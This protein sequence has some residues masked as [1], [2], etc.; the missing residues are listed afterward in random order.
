MAKR[1][2]ICN[3]ALAALNFCVYIREKVSKDE[4]TIIG[5]ATDED[6]ESDY[7]YLNHVDQVIPAHIG[8]YMDIEGIIKICLENNIKYAALGWG[9]LS[10]REDFAKALEDNDII[11]LGPSST[12][13]AALGDKVGSMILAE[14][15]GVPMAK[16]SGNQKLDSVEKCIAAV[17]NVGVPAMIKS[18]SGGGGRGIRAIRDLSEVASAYHNI[19]AEMKKSPEDSDVF[20]MKMIENAMHL[21]VQIVG[22]GKNAVHCYSRDCSCQ[23]SNQK[24]SES[25]VIEGE[26]IPSE[27]LKEIQE[28]AVR[29]A[30][31][32]NYKGLGTAEFLYNPESQE[33]VFLEK[34]VRQQVESNVTSILLNINLVHILYEICVNNK[35]IYELGLDK[36]DPP[37]GHVVAARLNAEDPYN[38]FLP[39]CGNVRSIEIPHMLRTWSYTS[40]Y[41]GGVIKNTMDGQLGHLFVKGNSREEACERMVRLIDSTIIDAD[42]PN[43][44]AFL[45][46]V[47]K[48]PTFV[49]NEHTTCWVKCMPRMIKPI[50]PETDTIETIIGLMTQG[51]FRY[52]MNF[53][54][55]QDLKQRGHHVEYKK[56]VPVAVTRFSSQSQAMALCNLDNNNSYVKGSVRIDK[57]RQ[58][59]SRINCELILFLPEINSKITCTIEARSREVIVLSF[60]HFM[61]RVNV[62]SAD[63]DFSSFRIQIKNRTRNFQEPIDPLEVRSKLDGKL[64]QVFV[65]DEC[66]VSAGQ[67]I[68]AL[69][70]MKMLFPVNVERD[71]NFK[72]TCQVGDLIKVGMLLGRFVEDDEESPLKKGKSKPNN[73]A[74][75]W[76]PEWLEEFVSDI[77]V[78]DFE[79]PQKEI[80]K[81]EKPLTPIEFLEKFEWSHIASVEDSS[82]IIPRNEYWQSFDFGFKSGI[83][84]WV[85]YEEFLMKPKCVLITHNQSIGYGSFSMDECVVFKKASELARKYECPRVYIANSSGARLDYISPNVIK[86]IQ[87]DSDKEQC[88]ITKSNFKLISE[89][90]QKR[91]VIDGDNID[92]IYISAIKNDGANNLDGCAMIASET[93]LAYDLI[94]TISYCSTYSVGIAAY[95]CRLGHRVIQK[96][97]SSLLLT[98]YRALNQLLSDDSIYQS[99]EQLGGVGVMGPNGVS[100]RI[101]ETDEQGVASIEQ[102]LRFV[103]YKT[104]V[105]NDTVY[106]KDRVPETLKNIVDTNSFYELMKGYATG[107][108]TGRARIGGTS[109]GVIFPNPYPCKKEVPVNPEDK[110]S[111]KQISNVAPSVLYPDTSYKFAQAI[112][113]VNREGLPLLIVLNLRG[114]SGGTMAMFTEVL[115]MGSKILDALRVFNQKCIL[116]IPDKSELRGGAQVVLSKSVNPDKIHFWVSDK[117]RVNILEVAG[118]F[119]VKY[120]KHIFR[121]P[122]HEGG[123]KQ[124]GTVDKAVELHDK[125]VNDNDLYEIVPDNQLRDKIINDLEL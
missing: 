2:L 45:K 1:L 3:R 18:A 124:S 57:C 35:T 25:S 5:L 64:V 31:S 48:N 110:S 97:G 104:S 7:K 107:I 70:S 79:E 23:R 118:G 22:D 62:C 59:D 34:N 30:E 101:V 26:H 67:S 94:P 75:L 49:R 73:A 58:I 121:P 69:E 8:I 74:S 68:V 13:I 112:N 47:F 76:F 39:A 50:S 32:V 14:K 54:R 10:E 114:F 29:L 42:F 24:I 43:T 98:G 38:D 40:I 60:G 93:S 37:K 96:K 51:Y 91:L 84:A 109:F 92:K 17:E 88:Y 66:V 122:R 20:V 117:S 15:A 95:L 86:M 105:P 36:L 116:Y 65:E 21:E 111:S 63:N 33:L 6:I 123:I 83:N 99:N 77:E 100:Q 72:L 106:I 113:D 78:D 61:F 9:F 115:K 12:A 90:N 108:K 103:N 80:K 125:V 119:D 82:K 56:D 87:Y 11:A 81:A 4:L 102:Y 44:L 19:N 85:L 120:K 27:V 53:A 71:G 89:E 52:C 41:S 46:T 28:S 55:E 16:W